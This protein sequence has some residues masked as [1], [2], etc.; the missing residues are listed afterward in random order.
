MTVV[1]L[2]RPQQMLFALL[3]LALW[4]KIS[5]KALFENANEI[6]WDE[7]YRLSVSHGISI[8]VLDGIILL[9]KELQPPRSVKLMWL[10][11][12]EAVESGYEQKLSFANEIAT[13]FAQNNLQMMIF[14]GIGLAQFYPIPK[15]REFLDIDFYLF[16]KKEEG[17]RLLLQSGAVKMEHGIDKH[18]VLIY[19]GI[20]LENHSYFLSEGRFNNV[21]A[22]EEILQRTLSNGKFSSNSFVNKALFPPPDFNILLILCHS[23]GHYFFERLFLRHLCDWVVFLKANK[24]NIDFETYRKVITEYNLIKFADA[25]TALAIKYL[26]LAPELAPPFNNDPELENRIIQESF[27]PYI[28]QNFENLSLPKIVR[29]KIDR[30][31]SRKWRYDEYLGPNSFYKAIWHSVIFHIC[32]PK[33]VIK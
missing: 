13:I 12:T 8:I 15:H 19:K 21:L 5:D 32:H 3:K 29:L 2:I 11:H 24:G 27:E 9:P 30:L 18:S 33:S 17:D 14:K 10:I 25:F 7:V 31:K 1:P 28:R 16:G 26:G 22:L 4:N 23:F 20:L 6:V